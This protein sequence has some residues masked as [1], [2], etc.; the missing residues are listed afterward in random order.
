MSYLANP[1][2]HLDPDVRE[3]RYRAACRAAARLMWA[4]HIVFSD[5]LKY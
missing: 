5:T 4:G 3:Q 2:S 1:Y